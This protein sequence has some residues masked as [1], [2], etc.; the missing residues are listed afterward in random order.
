MQVIS[1]PHIVF[2]SLK[3]VLTSGIGSLEKVMAIHSN[4]LTWRIPYIP[5]KL[6]SMGSQKSDMTEVTWRLMS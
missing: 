3:Y 6:P 1:L 5:G 4:I 2:I